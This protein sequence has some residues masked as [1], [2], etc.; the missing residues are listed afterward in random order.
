[1]EVLIVIPLHIFLSFRLFPFFCSFGSIIRISILEFLDRPSFSS[2]QSLIMQHSLF[3]LLFLEIL[4]LRFLFMQLQFICYNYF[5]SFS[6][7]SDFIPSFA[8]GRYSFL[9]S[10]SFSLFSRFPAVLKPAIFNNRKKPPTIIPK[11]LQ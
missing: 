9:N 10:L 3:L 8:F 4:F 7:Y 1:M 5:H 11:D 2:F 6:F